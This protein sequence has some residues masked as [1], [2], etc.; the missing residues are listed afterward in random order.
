M[1]RPTKTRDRT[2]AAFLSVAA[3]FLLP[4]IAIASELGC[5]YRDECLGIGTPWWLASLL[6]IVGV[7]VAWREYNPQAGLKVTVQGALLG[8]I[9]AG[10]VLGAALLLR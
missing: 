1:N 6:V 9:A 3:Q 7:I 8:V 4:H 5:D 2:R 10:A